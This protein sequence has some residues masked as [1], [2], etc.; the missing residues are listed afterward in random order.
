MLTLNHC[1]HPSSHK[2]TIMATSWLVF[3]SA[4]ALIAMTF[5]AVC[6]RRAWLPHFHYFAPQKRA[7]FHPCG[8]VQSCCWS[9]WSGSDVSFV[10]DGICSPAP[11]V[12]IMLSF[13][14]APFVWV[15]TVV[16]IRVYRRRTQ[17]FITQKWREFNGKNRNSGDVLGTETTF[18]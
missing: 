11:S 17:T 8:C 15:Y 9:G 14:Y 2:A 18:R 6:V 7:W 10:L 4:S 1:R 3:P 16:M 13:F 12:N 5:S